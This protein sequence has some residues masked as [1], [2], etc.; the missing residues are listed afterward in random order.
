MHPSIQSKVSQFCDKIKELFQDDLQSIILYGS[1][2][3]EDFIPK[4]S[5]LNFLVVLSPEGMKKLSAVQSSIQGWQK[6][7]VSIPL[8]L[9]QDYIQASLDVFPIEFLNMQ[10][11]YEVIQ[12]DDV[13]SSLKFK[14]TDLRLQCERELKGKLLHLRQSFIQT[15]GKA[16]LLKQLIADSV[17]TFTSIFAGLL[18]LKGRDIPKSKNELILAAC[19]EFNEIEEAFFEELFQ[20]RQKTLKLS[21]SELNDKVQEYILQIENLSHTVDQMK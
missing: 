9:T 19:R 12:G 17:V 13:L 20:I 10:N 21:K 15:Q 8:F 6:Q 11:A 7:K 16:E 2:T 14:K 18:Q 4:Q 1:A 5:D 3:T